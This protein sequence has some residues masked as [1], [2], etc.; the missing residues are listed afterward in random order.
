MVP[1]L[2]RKRRRIG[3][4]RK[5]LLRRLCLRRSQILFRENP[6][7]KRRTDEAALVIVHG[8]HESST[9]AATMDTSAF[10]DKQRKSPTPPT[11]S[12]FMFTGSNESARLFPVGA[13]TITAQ[14]M[15]YTHGFYSTRLPEATLHSRTANQLQDF[16]D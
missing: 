4:I 2:R 8:A 15:Q 12:Q 10:I 13:T 16:A 14:R 5:L 1:F 11:L 3:E 7:A 6:K 9:Y